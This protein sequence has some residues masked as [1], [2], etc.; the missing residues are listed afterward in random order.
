MLVDIR[1]P[2]F[3][4]LIIITIS[5]QNVLKKGYFN[6][7]KGGG[8]FSY[9]LFT[10]LTACMLFGGIWLVDP[11]FS[12]EVIPYALLFA[13]GYA[14]ATVFTLIALRCGSLSL[15][16]LV[17]SFSL[18]IPTLYGIIIDNEPIGI[19]MIIGL[20]L[21]AVSLVLINAEKGE[22]KITFGWTV[23]VTLAF[24]GNGLCSTV[25]TVQ[26]KVF[27][28]IYNSV[29]MF[30]S[31]IIVVVFLLVSAL[32]KEREVILSSF[33]GGWYMMVFA[34]AANWLCNLLVMLTSEMAP[35]SVF[36]PVISAGGIVATWLV[37]RLFYKESLS[38][39]QNAGMILGL[40]SIVL[41]N[42]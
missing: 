12:P 17:V 13:F 30:A 39:R 29:F 38:A 31:L 21:L 6:K 22:K 7:V 3:I 16:S 25:Q 18:I 2:M 15:T 40:A 23:A 11:Y 27:G 26:T 35:K 24:I 14:M 20:L 34:G 41:L 37:S 9:S 4:L 10:V 42:M 1:S 28:G 33:K 36:F 5:A 8:V 19:P 32:V